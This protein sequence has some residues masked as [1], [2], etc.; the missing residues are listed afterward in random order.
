MYTAAIFDLDGTLLNTI[1]DLS[2]ACNVA[3]KQFGYPEHTEE[4]YK[5]Y[6]GN[7]IYKL[8]ERA[9]PEE[10]RKNQD[11]VLETKA[12]FD[13]YYKE[14]SLDFTKPYEGIV[15]LLQTL[16][17]KGIKCGV[18]SNKAHEYTKALVKEMFGDL[19]PYV[20]GQREGVP[21]KPNPQGVFD[22][23]EDLKVQKAE[24][25]YIGDS[26]VDILTAQNAGLDSA[27]VLWGFRTKKELME[28]GAVYLV[29]D[30]KQLEEIILQSKN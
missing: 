2:I 5:T 1:T 21:T 6:V 15:E 24:C 11:K 14:H 18:V 20:Y 4:T 25:I 9:V 30:T 12:V 7:G 16:K 28:A 3:L 8:I 27:G 19:L 29:K 13:A 26:N 17:E 10:V 22:L 23:L